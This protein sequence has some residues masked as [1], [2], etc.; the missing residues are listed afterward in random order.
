MGVITIYSCSEL[1]KQSTV[2]LSIHSQAK[3]SEMQLKSCDCVIK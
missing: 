2:I 3:I 1:A